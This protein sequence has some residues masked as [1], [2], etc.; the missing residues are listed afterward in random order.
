MLFSSFPESRQRICVQVV[1]WEWPQQ[2]YKRLHKT[3]LGKGEGEPGCRRGLAS[4][5]PMVCSEAG[6]AFQSCPEFRQK[7]QAFASSTRRCALAAS[8]TLA[9]GQS[10]QQTSLLAAGEMS[11]SAVSQPHYNR[12]QFS[13]GKET[14]LLSFSYRAFT[15]GRTKS[16]LK[17]GLCSWFK[18]CAQ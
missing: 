4:A 1:Y 8:P 5:D 10:S 14:C 17:A 15:K 11:T 2:Q 7:D 13:F 3:R 12:S 16:W 9:E 6:M 18:S